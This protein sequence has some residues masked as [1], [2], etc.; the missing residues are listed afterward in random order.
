MR[1]GE[2]PVARRDDPLAGLN[3]PLLNFFRW[4]GILGTVIFGIVTIWFFITPSHGAFVGFL[5]VTI[6]FGLAWRLVA[7][8]LKKESN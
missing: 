8:R 6:L 1:K 7:Q 3:V 5:I 4:L 2:L